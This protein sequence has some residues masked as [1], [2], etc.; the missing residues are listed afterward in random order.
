DNR[1]LLTKLV[2][3]PMDLSRGFPF[4]LTAR[5][6]LGRVTSRSEWTWPGS[7]VHSTVFDYSD[8]GNPSQ[9]DPFGRARRV[10]KPDGKVSEMRYFGLSAGVTVKEVRG[11]NGQPLDSTTTYYHDGWDRLVYV[12]APPDGG[13]SA[14]Y[15]FDPLD[16]VVHV[17]LTE[18][19]TGK[20]QERNYEFDA[21]GRLRSSSNPETGS[22]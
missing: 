11:R 12:Q 20:V 4:Q 3:R 7:P 10:T 8:P 1:G 5:D 9:S 15:V 17:E 22:L 16:H 6:I 14:Y 19:T 21:L 13:A 18:A 2:K